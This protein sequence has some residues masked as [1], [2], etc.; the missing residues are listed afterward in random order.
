MKSVRIFI[1]SPGDV[2]DERELA[3]QVV[4]SLQRRY[5][6]RLLLKPLL[7]E[8]LPLQP[9]IT[10]Q[11]GIDLILSER[12]VDV[13]VFILWS[14]LGS[15]TGPMVTRPDG[16]PYRS[17]TER[18][19]DLM[20]RARAK[21]RESSGVARPDVLVYTR[22]D[23]ASWE[24]RLRGT[25]TS[26]K[27]EMLRQK[28]LVEGFISEEFEDA[29]TG[30]NLRAFHSFDR[31]R[32]FASRLR[33]HLQELLDDLGGLELVDP[34]WDIGEYGPPFMGLSP[35]EYEHAAAFSGREDETVA[36]HHALRSR[37]RDGI[38]FVLISG[39][40]GS[41]KSSL[42]RAGVLP[43]V[44]EFEIDE[45][46]GA[47]R[48][49]VLTPGEIGADLFG[50]LVSKLADALPAL[51]GDAAPLGDLAAGLREN[52]ELSFRLKI[53]DALAAQTG[54]GDAPLRLVVLVDQLE[55]LF[56][57]ARIGAELRN[58]FANALEVLA[59]SGQVWVIATMRSDFSHRCQEVAALV[60]LRE[61]GG[62]LDL[63][64][65]TAAGL[66]RLIT[67]PVRLAGLSYE[68]RDGRS[69]CDVL[70]QEASE[71][72]ELLPFLSHL[73]RRLV[74]Q[75][76][77][78]GRLTF[79]AYQSVL[80]GNLRD[81]LASYADEVFHQVPAAARATLPDVWSKIVT[82]GNDGEQA[83]RQ[84]PRLAELSA[85][86][87]M[88]DL[89][90]HLIEARLLVASRDPGGD[91]TVTVAHESLLRT[92]GEAT[93]WVDANRS[94]L[95]M[96]ANIDHY[97]QRWEQS[98]PQ[99]SSR[100]P[101]LLLPTGL[102]LEEGRKL[103]D[104]AAF[105]LAPPTREFIGQSLARSQLRETARRRRRRTVLALLLALTMTAG[106]AA[107]SAWSSK[108]DTEAVAARALLQT[109]QASRK[110]HG[111]ARRA[112]DEKG[113]A[114]AG[115]AYLAE[116][117]RYD[118]QNRLM[119]ASIP[120][121]LLR[122]R[123][124]LPVPS[125]AAMSHADTIETV[126]FSPDGSRL[127]TASHDG[128]AR[129]WD[130]ATGA[131]IGAPM[132][133][134]RALNSAH[135]S[136][137]GLRVL[138]ASWDKTARLWDGKTG[139][140]IGAAM[141]HQTSVESA[142]FSPDGTRILTHAGEEAQIWDAKNAARIGEALKHPSKIGE[143]RF[144]PGGQ[145]VVTASQDNLVRVWDAMTGQLVGERLRLIER[146]ISIEV[147][148][149]QFS[150]DGE[151]LLTVSDKSEVRWWD[152]GSGEALVPPIKY[153]KS[154]QA[155][156]S[157]HG[158]WVLIRSGETLELRDAESGAMIGSPIEMGA[159][160]WRAEFAA[161]G[162]SVL[163]GLRN[164]V[165]QLWN[166]QQA[167]ALSPPIWHQR[168][169][170][171]VTFASDGRRFATVSDDQAQVWDTLGGAP[172]GLVIQ[173]DAKVKFGAFSA[174]GQRIATAAGK[175]AQIWQ[176][177]DGTPVGKP[178]QHDDDIHTVEFSPDGRSL[179]TASSDRSARLWDV[180]SQ[181]QIGT[182]MRH[183]HAVN[184]ASFN[185]GGDLI[186]T[187]SIDKTARLW[188][189]STAVPFGEPLRHDGS[190]S[191]ARF[192]RQGDRIVTTSWDKTAR[193]WESTS[194][195]A[196][197]EPMEHG[198]YV[199]RAG[200]SPDGRWIVTASASNSARIW[201]ATNSRPE[202][203]ILVHDSVVADANYSPDGRWIVTASDSAQV[204]DPE[205]ARQFGGPLRHDDLVST[206]EFSPDSRWIL[207]TSFDRTARIWEWIPELPQDVRPPPVIADYL[208]MLGGK[209]INDE[210]ETENIPRAERAEWWRKFDPSAFGDHPWGAVIAWMSAD[211][212]TRSVSPGR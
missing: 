19:F 124:V 79:D 100:D 180:E 31:P 204:W 20:M 80:G 118:E 143:P 140:P 55:E 92:W 202:S 86:P 153:E 56:T 59:R 184:T 22:Q 15:P 175:F 141:T 9:D 81:A 36:V 186:L 11:Q 2:G 88:R 63:L 98:S 114:Q 178:I 6:G 14:R 72:R 196:V 130:P 95:R 64:P 73:L 105:L 69:L 35:Y 24:E 123:V 26:E 41:G 191:S 192:S 126:E 197:R 87:R 125:G 194:H 89:V 58:A 133:H 209:R 84:Y 50:G 160:V 164:G 120:N 145:W 148:T 142:Q 212:T 201:S 52:P 122:L 33:N 206:A 152:F 34:V 187:A 78:D 128:T 83:M 198:V 132:R 121:R 76:S 28:K 181:A 147:P 207:T 199:D 40:S 10:F 179:L 82:V 200:F 183:D 161:D 135:F 131:G 193:V 166:P 104:E 61:G 108:K 30:M 67:E 173:H 94:H 150:P 85:D 16:A 129:L 8:D 106:L 74:D 205:S 32:S 25:T 151:S 138:T 39:A 45:T 62:E 3:R 70:L 156:F 157:P 154:P 139:A 158:R 102:P 167:Q 111:A 75:R 68:E 48:H 113:D 4:Q 44:T 93:R 146:D 134:A 103:I 17:G 110:A 51:R 21:S 174:D 171:E 23:D 49:I 203:A 53:R 172:D 165:A 177:A 109:Q 169:V 38:A 136:P 168:Q 18:E 210:G 162:R 117:L 7:W 155:H 149:I 115:L 137:D 127:L 12:G 29:A 1:S 97:R 90:E 42:A 176:A 13:A 112:F 195:R 144:S 47:W 107:L 54:S 189:A 65:P 163:V 182:A 101:S 119:L 170:T 43:A 60:R 116:A 27:D 57:D 208:E 96:R 190:V 159:F 211:P 37:A 71:H 99:P 46:I 185:P 66:A 91:P 77:A 188:K 5:A